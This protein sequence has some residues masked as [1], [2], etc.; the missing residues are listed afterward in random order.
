MGEQEGE[1]SP[2][3]KA[4]HNPKL[5]PRRPQILVSQNTLFCYLFWMPEKSQ[6]SL[7]KDNINHLLNAVDGS[8]VGR[9]LP[10][11]IV[12]P[13]NASTHMI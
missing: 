11:L 8:V 12:F 9:V 2:P 10:V 5:Y 1:Y 4:V 6:V 3:D 13:K 7:V